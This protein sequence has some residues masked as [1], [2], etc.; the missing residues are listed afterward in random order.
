MG[1]K[2]ERVAKDGQTYVYTKEIGIIEGI[3]IKAASPKAHAGEV[4]R[5]FARV[6]QSSYYFLALGSLVVD[7]A[8]LVFGPDAC[9]SEGSLAA[10]VFTALERGGG[11]VEPLVVT[12]IWFFLAID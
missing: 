1:R 10:A 7:S 5:E 12:V 2:V 3:E 6:G 8:A 4:S 9:L 11:S